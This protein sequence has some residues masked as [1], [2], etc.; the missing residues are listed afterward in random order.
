MLFKIVAPAYL[1]SKTLLGEVYFQNFYSFFKNWLVK[2]FYDF[3]LWVFL[4]FWII[5]LYNRGKD[6]KI[7]YLVGDLSFSKLCL[8]MSRS[9]LILMKSN[10]SKILLWIIILVSYL[11]KLEVSNVFFWNFYSFRFNTEVYDPLW[12]HFL[13]DVRYGLRFFVCFIWISNCF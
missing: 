13:N 11:R 3:V 12:V 5:V 4:I 6:L 8:I 9:F 10:L 7:F 2:F 1:P